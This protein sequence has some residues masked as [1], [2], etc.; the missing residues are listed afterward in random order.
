MQSR[1][2]YVS[3]INSPTPYYFDNNG[4]PQNQYTSSIPVNAS[5]TFG[6]ATGN[7]F[8]GGGAKFYNAIS[9][10]TNLQGINATDYNNMIS[11]MSNQDDYRFN[12][13]VSPGIGIFP[14]LE[15]T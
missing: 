15:R 13:T 7:L 2:V 4:T 14:N 6:G 8:Y 9:G 10:T 1:Y 3:V 11:L 12:V 5:G